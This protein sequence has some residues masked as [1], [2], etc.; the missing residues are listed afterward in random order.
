MDSLFQVFAGGKNRTWS[1]LPT[2]VEE[3]NYYSWC[4][5]KLNLSLFI[6][7][8]IYFL[9]SSFSNGLSQRFALCLLRV[10]N[11]QLQELW[12]IEDREGELVSHEAPR[13]ILCHVCWVHPGLQNARESI[14]SSDSNSFTLQSLGWRWSSKNRLIHVGSPCYMSSTDKTWN[15]QEFGYTCEWLKIT[16]AAWLPQSCLSLRHDHSPSSHLHHQTRLILESRWKT[17][18]PVVMIASLVVPLLYTRCQ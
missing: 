10:D 13:C 2:Q 7:N 4:E 11:D 16:S 15:W 12:Q 18:E 3:L 6:L 1:L 9:E 14:E 5:I 17:D 8:Q